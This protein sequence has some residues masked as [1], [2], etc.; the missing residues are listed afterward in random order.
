MN[1]TVGGCRA[2]LGPLTLAM[3][4]QR[5]LAAAA[6]P[7][8]VIKYDSDAREGKGC[9]YGLA[10]SCSQRRNIETVL[11]G[12]RIRVRQWSGS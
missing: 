5:A 7:T 11:G 2:A 1:Y 9:L 10:F 12:E 3:R 4:A 8:T 6:I